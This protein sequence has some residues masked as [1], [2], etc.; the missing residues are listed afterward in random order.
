VSFK[1]N[2]WENRLASA[3]F[4]VVGIDYGFKHCVEAGN[5]AALRNDNQAYRCDPLGVKSAV[6]YFC[7]AGAL[8]LVRRD[9]D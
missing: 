6:N 3:W 9:A 1:G 5:A 4:W 8:D 2:L 7:E